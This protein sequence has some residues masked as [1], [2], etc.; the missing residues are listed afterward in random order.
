[1][2]KSTVLDYHE[3][4]LNAEQLEYW[5]KRATREWSFRPGPMLTFAKGLNTW[6]GVKSAVSVGVQTI[7]FVTS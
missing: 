4:G 5:Q 2:D 1:M 6:E 3:S 7:K